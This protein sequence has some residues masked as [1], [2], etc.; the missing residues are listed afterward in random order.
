MTPEVHGDVKTFLV[1][2]FPYELAGVPAEP[3]GTGAASG[4][5]KLGLEGGPLRF[6]LHHDLTISTGSRSHAGSTTS[7]IS[8]VAGSSLTGAETGVGLGAP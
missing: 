1:A 3:S 5:L 6:D 4:R 8:T 7:E 2:S